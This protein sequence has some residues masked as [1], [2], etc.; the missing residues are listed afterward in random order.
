MTHGATPELPGSAGLLGNPDLPDAASNFT[1]WPLDPSAVAG[2]GSET[3]LEW[4]KRKPTEGG[5]KRSPPVGREPS[6][7]YA[8]HWHS[9]DPFWGGHRTPAQGFSTSKGRWELAEALGEGKELE[10]DSCGVNSGTDGH[11]AEVPRL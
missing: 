8:Q 10:L 4:I 6:L 9:R 11:M 1:T 2:E 3:K 5:E 7:F